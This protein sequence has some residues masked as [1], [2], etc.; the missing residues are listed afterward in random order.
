MLTRQ[1]IRS[2]DSLSSASPAILNRFPHTRL[3]IPSLLLPHTVPAANEAQTIIGFESSSVTPIALFQPLPFC[4]DSKTI[5]MN[6][7][8]HQ[9][10]MGT[11]PIY[12]IA[13]SHRFQFAFVLGRRFFRDFFLAEHVTESLLELVQ[14][15]VVNR[16]DV[17]RQRLGEDQ[18]AN[19]RQAERTA[20]LGACA[21]AY[22]D[23]QRAHQGSHGG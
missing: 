8:R 7:R 2:C 13:L 17:E 3:W 12:Q 18:A 5:F 1:Q 10:L 23:G 11:L 19:H 4:R 16:G 20:G 6:F 21:K 9:A 22:S 14:V 15:N